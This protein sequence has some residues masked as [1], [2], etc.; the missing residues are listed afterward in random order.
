MSVDYENDVVLVTCANGKQA[1][2]L[3]PFLLPKWKHLRLA[4]KSESSRQELL[5]KHTSKPLKASVEVVQ[6]DLT[7][8]DD[9]KRICEGVTSVFHIGPSFHPRETDIGYLFLSP[10]R[11]TKTKHHFTATT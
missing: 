3:I 11:P 2:H 1:A 5:K 8:P 6:A 7:Q 10:T 9:C 4:V